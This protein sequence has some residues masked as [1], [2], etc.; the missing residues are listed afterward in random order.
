VLVSVPAD[1]LPALADSDPSELERLR[2]DVAAFIREGKPKV[3]IVARMLEVG[4]P[5]PFAV[6]FIEQVDAY[7]LNFRLDVPQDQVV[8]EGGRWYVFAAWAFGILGFFVCPVGSAAVGVYYAERALAK[9]LPGARVARSCC[10]AFM[11]LGVVVP[12]MLIYARRK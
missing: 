3:D 8:V 6:W 4:W 7:G 11:A 5:E 12:L 9:G 10:Y 2:K 1:L